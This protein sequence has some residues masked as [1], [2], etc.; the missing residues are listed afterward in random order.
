LHQGKDGPLHLG[1]AFEEGR[2]GQRVQAFKGVA[3]QRAHGVLQAGAQEPSSVEVHVQVGGGR[4]PLCSRAFSSTVRGPE[5]W[6]APR[7][8]DESLAPRLQRLSMAQ[9]ACLSR[10]SQAKI[11]L[12]VQRSSG[13]SKKPAGPGHCPAQGTRSSSSSSSSS[14][15]CVCVC[16]GGQAGAG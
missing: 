16:G 7:A 15:V 10:K 14:H 2:P 6:R 5:R 11:W 4:G 8:L 9:R 13:P 1:Q 12:Y 3:L